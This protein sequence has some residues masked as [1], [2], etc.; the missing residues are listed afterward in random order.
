M[1]V[2]PKSKLGLCTS[3]VQATGK[4]KWEDLRVRSQPGLYRE[5]LSPNNVEKHQKDVVRWSF[6]KFLKV[7]K[8]KTSDS[9]C[10]HS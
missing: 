8:M 6:L 1:S 5:I 7:T 10:F 4:Q 3:V 2:S 9:S